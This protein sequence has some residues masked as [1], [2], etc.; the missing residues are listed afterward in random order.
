MNQP[1]GW[2][3]ESGGEQFECKELMTI[4]QLLL[5]LKLTFSRQLPYFTI[6]F[7]CVC[8]LYKMEEHTIT[9]K[10]QDYREPLVA[11]SIKLSNA[12][13]KSEYLCD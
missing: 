11:R 3:F 5:L 7:I 12:T 6:L 10:T 4:T 13:C 9:V 2:W 8:K 1:R